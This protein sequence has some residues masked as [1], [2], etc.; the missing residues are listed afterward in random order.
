[1]RKFFS[2][3]TNAK[4]GDFEFKKALQ[5]AIRC[6]LKMKSGNDIEVN[7]KK[8]LREPGAGQKPAVPEV[9]SSNSQL[10]NL[11]MWGDL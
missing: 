10:N 2:S 6:Y 5:L 1:M 3:L 8:K 11:S 9:H 7:S 4:S